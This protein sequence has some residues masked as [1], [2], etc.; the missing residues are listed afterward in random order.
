MGYIRVTQDAPGPQP[1][2]VTVLT[3]VSSQHLCCSTLP[4]VGL[5]SPL[6]RTWIGQTWVW[7]LAS[8]TD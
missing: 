4:L 1:L 2:G 7:H 8:V 3:A 5:R 6:K